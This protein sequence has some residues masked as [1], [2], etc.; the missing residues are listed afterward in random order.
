M[1]M[2]LGLPAGRYD[3]DVI[4]DDALIL[5]AERRGESSS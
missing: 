2:R 1:H 4:I 3:S 5:E